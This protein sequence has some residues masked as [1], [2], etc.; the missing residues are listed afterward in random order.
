MKR[1]AVFFALAV[2][3]V[4]VFGQD[5]ALPQPA[6]K[7]GVDLY[8]AIANRSI[9]RTFVKKNLSMQDL[10]TILWAGSG[11]RPVDA[12]SSATKAG[13]TVSFS[14]DNPYINLYVLTDT[15]AWK[16]IPETNKLEARSGKSIREEVS[17]GVIPA[18]AFMVLFT[19]DN[20][21]MP[22]FLKNNPGL[23]LQMA[24][25][26]AGF[27]A[28]NIAL[29]ASALK[30]ASIIKYTLNAKGAASVLKLGKDEIPLFTIQVG[31]TQ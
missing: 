10:S 2:S 3:G 22:P 8:A 30:M 26:T 7:S 27:A 4:F 19:V 21:L 5:I 28:Q 23:F 29:S 14:G 13:R 9:S 11:V 25:G 31:Y 24:N 1:L 12:V 18:S 20:A 15:G 6:T 17:S 16:Y